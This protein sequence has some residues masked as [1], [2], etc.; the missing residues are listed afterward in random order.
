M[1]KGLLKFGKMRIMEIYNYKPT[2][3]VISSF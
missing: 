3:F 2:L 1:K